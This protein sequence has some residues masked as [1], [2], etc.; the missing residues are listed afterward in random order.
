L[1]RT[2]VTANLEVGTGLEKSINHAAVNYDEE[3]LCYVN[4]LII[5]R[6]I[7]ALS[8]YLPCEF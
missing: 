8:S 3:V 2:A 7:L 6:N 5:I 1:N 4:I